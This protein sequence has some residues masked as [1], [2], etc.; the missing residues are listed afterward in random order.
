MALRKMHLIETSGELSLLDFLRK[1]GVAEPLG[2]LDAA[3]TARGFSRSQQRRGDGFRSFGEG[4]RDRVGLRHIKVN[5]P[6]VL[7]ELLRLLHVEAATVGGAAGAGVHARCAVA[8][9]VR[10]RVMHPV[11]VRRFSRVT[12]HGF[13]GE[14]KNGRELLLDP[15]SDRYRLD[16]PADWSSP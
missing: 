16:G 13:R 1:V 11:V 14:E 7:V 15:Y 4:I 12:F 9:R 8:A 2:E 10:A 5:R 3:V 6:V